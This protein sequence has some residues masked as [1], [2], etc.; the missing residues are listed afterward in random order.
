M[1]KSAVKTN[2]KHS[3]KVLKTSLQRT[4]SAK[5]RLT[6]EERTALS[7]N[8]MLEIAVHLIN[9][10]GTHNTTL[11][12]ISEYAGY[13]R[14]LASVRFGTKEVLFIELLKKF[15]RRWKE[16]STHAV[17]LLTG[18]EAFTCANQGLIAFFESE[19]TFIRVMYLIGYEMAG[20]SKTMREHLSVQ[21]EAYRHG[22]AR[23][24]REAIAEGQIKKEID[25]ERIALQ[26][27]SGVFGLIY[28][29]LIHPE[30]INIVQGLE[31]LRE[32]TIAFIKS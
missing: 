14:G 29:W 7:Y 10:K 20:S 22:V 24:I 13:S 11:K 26:Y 31:D 2:S 23:W 4:K 6:Q 27:C 15:N 30:V 12:D 16:E 18:L 9:E 3:K 5:Q 17:G 19:S 8:R 28:Q 25:P 21:H 32:N 1:V